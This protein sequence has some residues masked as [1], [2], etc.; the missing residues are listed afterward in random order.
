MS[1]PVILP[2]LAL[3]EHNIE[4]LCGFLRNIPLSS[5]QELLKMV[6]VCSS[7]NLNCDL[8]LGLHPVNLK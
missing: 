4:K 3:L 5:T 1:V 6:L 7:S 2:R 8:K